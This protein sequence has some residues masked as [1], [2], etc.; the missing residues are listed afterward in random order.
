MMKYIRKAEIKDIERIAEIEVFNYRLQFYPIFKEDDFYFKD[1]TVSRRAAHY[2]KELESVWVYD[3]GVVKGF[4][5][6]KER[7]VKKLFVEPVL[8]GNGIGAELLDYAIDQ[9]NVNFLWVLEKNK[10]AMAFYKRH[11]FV[12]T[13]EKKYEEDTTEFL[14]CMKRLSDFE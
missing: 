14:V 6:V 3:D 12:E 8:Q 5:Q 11:G 10:R 7:E 9:K 13:N 1:L 2:A 4:V